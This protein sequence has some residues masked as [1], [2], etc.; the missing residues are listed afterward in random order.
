VSTAKVRLTDKEFALSDVV[1]LERP[2]WHPQKSG[3]ID[4][5]YDGINFWCGSIGTPCPA[6]GNAPVLPLTGWHHKARCRCPGCRA[7]GEAS[8]RRA[9][10]GGMDN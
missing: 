5:I 4:F 9:G 6:D 10:R 8:S 1:D 3:E 7:Q 2:A